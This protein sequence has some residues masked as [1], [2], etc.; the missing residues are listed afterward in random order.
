MKPSGDVSFCM[1]VKILFAM[2]EKFLHINEKEIGGL[3]Y[4]KI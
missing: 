4:N 2:F 1:F 3:G